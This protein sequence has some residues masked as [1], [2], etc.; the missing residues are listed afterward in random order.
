MKMSKEI[1]K[2]QREQIETLQE[3]IR[4][5]QALLAP[6]KYPIPFEWRLSG[7]ERRTFLALSGGEFRTKEAIFGFLYFDMPGDPPDI[8]IVDMYIHKLRC[9]LKPFGV[10]I[11]T[12]WGV[13][14]QLDLKSLPERKAA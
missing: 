2:A 4:Q 12:V 9:K 14:Y 3:R 13:G 6:E 5:L 11:D 10:R 1:I 7:R 8:K